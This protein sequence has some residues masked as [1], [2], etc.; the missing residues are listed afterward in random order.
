MTNSD[1]VILTEEASSI[2]KLCVE[3]QY[4]AIDGKY[5]LITIDQL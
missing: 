2:I 1:S 3:G 5:W 4:V